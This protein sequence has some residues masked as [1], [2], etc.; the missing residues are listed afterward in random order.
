M[1]LY[2]AKA[3]SPAHVL[4]TVTYGSADRACESYLGARGQHDSIYIAEVQEYTNWLAGY[5][6]G[7]NASSLRTTNVLGEL[8]LANAM[9]RLQEWCAL[10]PRE[11]FNAAVDALISPRPA[12]LASQDPGAARH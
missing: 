5:L 10:H 8:S 7:V 12:Q 4:T 11:S 3:G 9:D 6:S 1:A 2:G